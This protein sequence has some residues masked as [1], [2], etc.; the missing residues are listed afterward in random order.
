VIG[1][2]NGDLAETEGQIGASADDAGLRAGLGRI[3]SGLAHYVQRFDAVVELQ[4][5]LG[6][7]EQSGLQ[8]RL[9]DTVQAVE[10]RL[11][12]YEDQGLTVLMLTMR[13]HEKDFMLRGDPRH[14]NE[15]RNRAAEF[16]KALTTSEI[17]PKARTE[18]AEALAAYQRD[19]LAFIE[20]HEKF[21]AERKAV[22]DAYVAVEPV[23]DDV[24]KAIDARYSAAQMAAQAAVSRT[25]LQMWIAIGV[26]LVALTAAA[27]ATGRAITRP[28]LAMTAA[29]QRVA[30]GDYG[31][32]VPGLGRKN[33]IGAMAAAIQVFKTNGE[34][35]AHLRT[36]QERRREQ[37]EAEKR[38][39]MAELARDFE[40][41]VGALTRNLTSAATELEATARSMT[42]VADR[43]TQGT[44]SVASAAEQASGNV[45]TVAAA[46]EELSI[47]IGEIAAQ[48]AESSSMT[49]QASDDA[50][51]TDATV[52]TLAGSAERIGHV[53][54]LIGTIASQT[55][56]LAL[57]AAIEAARAGEA[58]KGFAVV[59]AE[60]KELASQT[61]RATNEIA[62]QIAAIQEA[63]SESVGAIQGIVRTISEMSRISTMIA[64]AM[65][66]QGAATAEIARNVQEAARGTE[67]V[68]GTI[69]DVRQGAGATGAAAARVLD[70][71][72]ALARTSDGLSQEVEA[73][74]SGFKAA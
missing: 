71:A 48:V 53:I 49:R 30:K 20:T 29:M 32:P 65:E 42:S 3:K 6:M 25:S 43:T 27:L 18:L 10:K 51:R 41:K 45:R 37:S 22:S 31:A 5:T 72:Q 26:I 50:R 61:S 46:A 15:I 47:S 1:D 69:G 70:A 66:E 28:L 56:L 63:T 55:N 11:S 2:V 36:E 13:Q 17:P 67:A 60:V 58:G 57:N 24:L 44:V 54:Q 21:M 59:A 33:E 73:F 7:D 16:T 38:R 19:V 9:S 39:A 62:A 68:S 64:A 40:G 52:Q 34:E 12:L 35:M 14:G 74:L 8:G 23:V 4:R